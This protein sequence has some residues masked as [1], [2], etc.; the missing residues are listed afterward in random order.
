ML[1]PTNK[2]RT[3]FNNIIGPLALVRFLAIKDQTVC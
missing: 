3:A 1:E 2:Q